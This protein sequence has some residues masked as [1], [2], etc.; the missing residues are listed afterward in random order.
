[1]EEAHPMSTRWWSEAVKKIHQND[2]FI[3]LSNFCFGS[4][5]ARVITMEEAHP[6]ST[7]WRSEAVKK[8]IISI[9]SLN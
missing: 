8:Y 4:K 5:P 1:M 9:S 6:M 7:G 3:K 2:Q